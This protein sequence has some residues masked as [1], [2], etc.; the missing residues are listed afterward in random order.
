M[1]ALTSNL[2]ET[3]KLACEFAKTL[4]RGSVLAFFGDLGTGKTTFIRYLTEALAG[5]DSDSVSSPTFQ[6]LNIYNGTIP[7][8]HFDLYRLKSSNDFL[9]LGFDEFLSHQGI[10]CIEWAERIS[11]LLPHNTIHIHITHEAEGIRKIAIQGG[12]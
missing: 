8:Y 5:V 4:K 10:S 3:K 9:F 12:T 1:I 11:D 7:I 6:Y 2:E